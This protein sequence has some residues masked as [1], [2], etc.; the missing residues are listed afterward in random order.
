MAI[1]MMGAEDI[2]AWFQAEMEA[3]REA[4][5]NIKPWQR[6]IKAGDYFV[7]TSGGISIYSEVLPDD[8]EEEEEFSRPEEYRFTRSYSV[9]CPQGERGDVHLSVVE[10]VITRDEFEAFRRQ[11]WP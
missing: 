9:A 10:R 11:S 1:F 2:E 5:K 6:E 3:Q 7:R 8:D 4:A